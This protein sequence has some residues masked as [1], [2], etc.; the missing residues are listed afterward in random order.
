MERKWSRNKEEI[1]WSRRGLEV[2][3]KRKLSGSGGEE[4]QMWSSGNKVEITRSRKGNKE[5]IE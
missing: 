1:K 4:E 5:E 2:E 3:I